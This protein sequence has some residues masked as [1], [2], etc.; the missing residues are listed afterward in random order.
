VA[1]NTHARRARISEAASFCLAWI[2]THRLKGLFAVCLEYYHAFLFVFSALMAR[3]V[4]RFRGPDIGI[5]EVHTGH[6]LSRS[7]THIA[8]HHVFPFIFS[9]QE[10]KVVF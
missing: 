4:P 1:P 5:V 7:T 8:I 9:P 10:V 3:L 6:V 2:R